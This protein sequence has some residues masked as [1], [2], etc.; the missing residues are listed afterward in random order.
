MK[1]CKTN[2]QMLFSLRIKIVVEFAVPE[3]HQTSRGQ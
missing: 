1:P 3:Q 2:R